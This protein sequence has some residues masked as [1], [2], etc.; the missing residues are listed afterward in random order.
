MG[1]GKLL[2]E[3]AETEK[4]RNFLYY[5]G[6]RYSYNEFFHRVQ[7]LAGGLIELGLAPGERVALYLGS[8]PEFIESFYAVIYAGGIVVPLN[9]HWKAGELHYILK[10]SQAKFL[11]FSS[12]LGQEIRRLELSGLELKNLIVVGEGELNGWINYQELFSK[13]FFS[14][15]EESDGQI[16]S[17]IYTSGA[18]GKP[19]GVM[20][21]HKNYLTNLSQLQ[22]VLDTYETDR[23][24]GILPLFHVLGTMMFLLPIFSGG[25][26]VLFSEFSPRKVLGALQEFQISV[27]AGVPTVYAILSNLPNHRSLSFSKLRYAVCGGAPLSV[28]VIEQ[29]EKRYGIELLEGY[30]LS[31][32]TCACSL[33]PPAGKRKPGSVGPALPGERIKI[34]SESESGLVKEL[35]AN[36][37]GEILVYGENVMRGYWRNQTETEQVLKDG[38]LRT[39]DL[40][41]YDRD[42]YYYIKGR[43][44]DMIIR[45]GEN[46]YPREVEEVLL[47]H[48]GI[49]EVAV[50]G[51]PDRV[52]GE[53]VMVFIVP[54]DNFEI[55]TQ[56]LADFCH[57]HLADF[58]CPKLWQIIKE[59][60][61]TSAGEVCKQGLLEKY[62]SLRK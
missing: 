18:T 39:G 56:E 4:Q 40:G 42:G 30:G 51:I 24:L 59:L 21:S 47:T 19:K 5:E 62:W 50:V 43:K 12:Q 46:I 2:K 60:P 13:K 35:G 22:V 9:S 10:N 1:L 37:V 15:E 14:P 55:K 36:E 23:T 41:Y 16:A 33:N 11:I 31:E 48:P 53:E 32:A 27:F 45:G 38:W 54:R 6:V 3:R 25:S 8:Q 20:L 52:W 26:L 28:E 34:M 57:S 44:K 29:F 17:I 58:K 7:S 61:K 49:S